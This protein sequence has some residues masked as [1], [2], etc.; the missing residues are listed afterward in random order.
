MKGRIWVDETD[1]QISRGTVEF[2]EDFKLGAGRWSK[3]TKALLLL[4]AAE[5]VKDEV[6]YPITMKLPRSSFLFKALTRL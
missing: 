3:L 4:S 5:E 6:C 1:F 2:I